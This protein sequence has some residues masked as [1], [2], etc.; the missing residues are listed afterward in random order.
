MTKLFTGVAAAACIASFALTGCHAGPSKGDI[1][2]ALNT[3]LAKDS[4]VC[5]SVTDRNAVFPLRVSADM[6]HIH[7][8]LLGMRKEGYVALSRVTATG[9]FGGDILQVQVTPAGAG[10]NVWT[11]GQGFCVGRKVVDE[12]RQWT[13]PSSA[14]GMSVTYV[15]FTWKVD[16]LPGWANRDDFAGVGG[17]REPVA[18]KVAL[19]KTNSGWQVQQ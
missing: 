19:V 17:M 6:Q 10:K 7:P 13:V 11:P 14:E 16:D 5:W 15:D 2:D 12:V 3:G 9:F 8:I 18:A 4:S 1:K